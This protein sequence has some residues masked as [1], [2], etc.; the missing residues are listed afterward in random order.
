MARRQ[1]GPAL[2]RRLVQCARAVLAGEV[3]VAR[4]D[5]IAG[6]FLGRATVHLFPDVVKVIALH[7]GVSGFYRS[8]STR[9]AC[10]PSAYAA[11]PVMPFLDFGGRAARR[12]GQALLPPVCPISD[13]PPMISTG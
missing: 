13:H 7:H 4:P 11:S 2:N 12:K 8:S 9:S 6:R 3:P 1:P 5:V 10:G